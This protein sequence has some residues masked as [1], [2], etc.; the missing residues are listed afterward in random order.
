VWGYKLHLL[1]D[2]THEIPIAANLT[3]GNFADVNQATPLLSQARDTYGKFHP[4]YIICDAAYSSRVLRKACRKQFHA[5]PIIKAR[6][7]DRWITDETPEW[8]LI[9]DRRT[10]VER[11][12]SR[13]KTQR[14]LNN[15]TVRSRRKVSVHS[16]IPVIVTQAMALAFPDSPRNCIPAII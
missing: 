1:V 6:K 15:V 12:F 13:M 11:V 5:E 8:Q 14:R 10:A 4:D 9:F 7:T 3:R 16:L 2:T